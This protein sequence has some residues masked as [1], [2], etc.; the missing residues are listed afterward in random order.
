MERK[1]KLYDSHTPCVT[2][3]LNLMVPIATAPGCKQCKDA[4]ERCQ[5]LYAVIQHQKRHI[6]RTQNYLDKLRRLLAEATWPALPISPLS[7][8]ARKGRFPKAAIPTLRISALGK[9]A[10][11]GKGLE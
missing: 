9:P 11:K 3:D 8:P 5:K 10:Q 1:R 4:A 6:E 2:P 7:R